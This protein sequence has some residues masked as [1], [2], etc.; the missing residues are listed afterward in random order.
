VATAAGGWRPGGDAREEA[1]TESE[2]VDPRVKQLEKENARL[3]RQL[4]QAETIIDSQKKL[5]VPIPLPPHSGLPFALALRDLRP[6][7]DRC[8]HRA[9][10]QAGAPL[11]SS[12]AH[13][14]RRQVEQP[15]GSIEAGSLAG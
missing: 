1:G 8:I 6:V 14:I 3:Q 15:V 12:L 4:K 10:C 2:V 9:E 13:R 5:P 7:R 11:R